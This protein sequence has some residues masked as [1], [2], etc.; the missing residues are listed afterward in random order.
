MLSTRAMVVLPMVWLS[1]EWGA[2]E[3]SSVD[4]DVVKKNRSPCLIDAELN[5]KGEKTRRTN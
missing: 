3:R 1:K 5:G 2:S 4:S